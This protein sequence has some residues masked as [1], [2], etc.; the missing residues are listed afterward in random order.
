MS[1]RGGVVPAGGPAP[2]GVLL[3]A[4]RGRRLGGFKQL[5]PWPPEAVPGSARPLVRHAFD[6]VAA[7]CRGVVVVLGH[8]PEAVRRAI[9]EEAGVFVVADPDAPMLASIQTGLRAAAAADSAAAIL[10]HLGDVPSV[11]PAT[12]ATLL[13]AAA[14]RPETAKLPE[15]AGRGGHPAWVPPPVRD[16]LLALPANHPGGVRAFWESRPDL[17]ER[18]PVPDAGCTRDIDRPEDLAPPASSPESASWIR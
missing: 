14:A 2:L 18:I 5:R 15:H 11:A 12:I 16:R 7:A 10:L 8:E 6:A 3:A 17:V 1:G 13:T 9:G 4:G